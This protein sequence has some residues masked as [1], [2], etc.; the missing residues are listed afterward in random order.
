MPEHTL[1][2]LSPSSLTAV[3]KL[4][5]TTIDLLTLAARQHDEI[6]RLITDQRGCALDDP[7]FVERLDRILG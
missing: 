3:R 2:E 7:G 5:S 4:A 1:P 6:E